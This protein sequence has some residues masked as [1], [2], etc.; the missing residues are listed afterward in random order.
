MDSTTKG[1]CSEGVSGPNV[2]SNALLQPDSD[3]ATQLSHAAV[4]SLTRFQKIGSLLYLQG[5][6]LFAEEAVKL[7]PANHPALA[8]RLSNLGMMLQT[9]HAL[10]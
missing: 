10:D 2:P 6:L 3:M 9:K 8:N 7:T 1:S 4:L 5:A